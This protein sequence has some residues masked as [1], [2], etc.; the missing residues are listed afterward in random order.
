MDQRIKEA[1]FYE[2]L[3]DSVKCGTCEKSCIIRKDKIGFCKTRKNIGGKIFT[4]IYGDIS[5]MN[6]DK[7][8]KKP[9]FH[10]FPRSNTLTVGSL[11]CNFTCPWC[12]NFGISKMSENIGKGEYVPPEKLIKLAVKQKCQGISISYNEPVLLLEYSLDVFK[13][14]KKENLYNTYVSNGYMTSDA[15][16]TLVKSGLDAMNID[17]KG[18]KNFVKKYCGA[19]DEKILRNVKEARKLGV[20]IELTTLVIPKFNDSV[21]SLRYVAKRIVDIDKNIPWHVSRFYPAWKFDNV[22]PTPS[23]SLERAYKIGKEEGLK[24]I[25]VGNIAGNKLESTYCPKCNEKLIERYGFEILKN[26]IKNGKC[27]K[28]KEKIPIVEYPRISF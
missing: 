16:K 2:K 17:I 8:E 4:L 11:G 23:E 27:P 13:L 15:L 19:D 28:C 10:F 18:D 26:K 9:F 25:Y 22:P 14:A 7:I 3:K 5:S 20:W 12:Q 21:K 1:L 24:F 6:V